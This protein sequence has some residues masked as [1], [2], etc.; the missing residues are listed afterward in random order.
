[1]EKKK[2]NN[3]SR[4]P[5]KVRAQV[6]EIVIK[7]I[8]MRSGYNW[9]RSI[10]PY[11]AMFSERGRINF[12]GLRLTEQQRVR[13]SAELFKRIPKLEYTRY[14]K[15]DGKDEKGRPGSWTSAFMVYLD[16]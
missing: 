16:Y 5:A 11:H 1:M 4:I 15:G 12:W 3:R 9:H 8:G 14:R 6:R 10:V 13:L 2:R 7:M